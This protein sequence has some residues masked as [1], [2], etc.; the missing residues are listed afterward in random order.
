[1]KLE[2]LGVNVNALKT[3]VNTRVFYAWVEDWEK[4][5]KS[6]NDPVSEQRILQKYKGLVF[7]DAEN[8]VN[9]TMYDGNMEWHKRNMK[10]G[11]DYTGWYLMSIDEN[12]EYH[13]WDVDNKV[14]DMLA[15]H[16]QGPDVEVIRTKDF[17][18]SVEMD[19]EES[20]E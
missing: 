6:S 1:M 3:N 2:K 4:E 9:Q 7:Y 10:R 11:F 18:D 12:G 5:A 19:L 17:E 14:C 13:S 20:G 16:E 15:D 8:E